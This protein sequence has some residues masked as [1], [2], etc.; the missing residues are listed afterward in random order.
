M[1]N[2]DEIFEGSGE[3]I[4]QFNIPE[5]PSDPKP[6]NDQADDFDQT[7]ET[8][9]GVRIR[10]VDMD[11]NHLVN[12]INMLWRNAIN[13][14]ENPTHV[15]DAAEG[16][17][18][19]EGDLSYQYPIEDSVDSRYFNMVSEAEKRTLKFVPPHTKDWRIGL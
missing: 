17:V 19:I 10:I 2:T 1:E 8:K 5:E 9:Q 13:E 6:V 14:W 18:F 11:D 15:F 12:T 3:W 7:W 16:P 4:A